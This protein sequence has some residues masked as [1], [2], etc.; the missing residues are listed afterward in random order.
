M[1]YIGQYE[2]TNE[3]MLF[4]NIEANIGFKNLKPGLKFERKLLETRTK[5]PKHS[6]PSFFFFFFFLGFQIWKTFPLHKSQLLIISKTYYLVEI[7][8]QLRRAFQKL[9]AFSSTELEFQ[10]DLNWATKEMIFEEKNW[11]TFFTIQ[12]VNWVHHSFFT[13]AVGLLSRLCFGRRH[14]FRHYQQK[15]ASSVVSKNEKGNTA[16]ERNYQQLHK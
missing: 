10:P 11:T 5:V 6:S 4:D 9:E 12:E 16:V 14:K 2:S 15:A 1:K 7:S 3:W 8:N 13:G